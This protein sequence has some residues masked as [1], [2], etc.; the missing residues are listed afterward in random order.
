MKSIYFSYKTAT[1]VVNAILILAAAYGLFMIYNFQPPVIRL[2]IGPG[3]YPA[4]LCVAL[5]I[6]SAISL[7]KTFKSRDDRVIELPKIVNSLLVIVV[8]AVFLVSWKITRQFYAVSFIL[9]TILLY[10]LNPQQNSIGKVVKAVLISLCI[11]AFVY[12]VF[13]RL[14]YFRF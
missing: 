7:I 11:Q 8:F 5:V 4:L 9:M 3:Y 1:Y 2:R 10:F 12:L 13:Q 6:T 14:M